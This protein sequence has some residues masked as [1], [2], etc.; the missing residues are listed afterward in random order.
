MLNMRLAEQPAP[1]GSRDVDQLVGWLLDTLEF[2]RRSGD[3]WTGEGI[4]SPI[5]RILCEHMLANPGNGWDAQT[6]GDELGLS[7]TAI[8][9]QLSKLNEC[10][11][12]AAVNRDGWRVHHL[13]NGSLSNAVEIMA[14]EARLVL[15]QRLRSLEG[16][17]TESETRMSSVSE[18]K[19]DA[20]FHIQIRG[21]APLIKG[22]DEM[23]AFLLDLGL[24]GDRVRR[25][26]DGSAPLGRLIF[27]H[28]LIAHTPLSL[29]E[30]LENWGTTRPR[31]TRTL[32]RF[33]AAGLAERVPRL[34]RL[35]VTLWSALQA[36]HNRR[37]GDWLMKKGG[38]SRIDEK[39]AKKVVKSLGSGSFNVAAC[40]KIF[41][42][43]PS[44][45]LML[46]LN[47]LGGKLPIGWRLCG[48]KANQVCERVLAKSDRTFR[49]IKRVAETLEK[50]M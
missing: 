25:P 4:H 49:R 34:D 10:G 7:P 36:Q 15:D 18:K 13:R 33:R 11:L 37:G 24:L 46:L 48:A 26:T 19:D 32:D 31:L 39:I 9:Y 1:A 5:H 45:D 2:V 40:E 16:W 43:V 20:P 47:L 44:N 35:P 30:A 42:T 12:T 3:E 27:E 23:D 21:R 14:A 8:Q 50:V 29:D 17:M 41:A 38:L 22:Q 28:L 6:L